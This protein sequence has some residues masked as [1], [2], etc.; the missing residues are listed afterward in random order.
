METASGLVAILDRG[1][2]DCPNRR[3]ELLVQSCR[4]ASQGKMPGGLYMT[5]RPQAR[6]SAKD[7]E[8]ICAAAR[9]AEAGTADGR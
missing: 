2:G 4:D 8:T 9:Q 5:L 7:V 3:R 6:L 1:C